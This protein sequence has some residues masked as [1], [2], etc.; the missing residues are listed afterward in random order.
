MASGTGQASARYRIVGKLGGGG[1]GVVFKAEDTSLGRFV[2]LKLLP[3]NLARDPL[4]LE[5]LRREARAASALDHPNICTVYDITTQDGQLAIAMQ[6]LEG[7]TLKG[8]LAGGVALAADTVV[9]LGIQIADALAAAHAKGIIHRD[10]KPANI[11]VTS[12]GQAKVLDFGLAK[13]EATA[14]PEA[15]TLDA[16]PSDLT[17]PGTTLGTAAYMSPE[18]ALGEPLDVRSDLFSLGTVLYEMATGRLP[19]A[20]ATSVAISDAILHKTPTPPAQLNPQLPPELARIIERALEKD[21]A[22]RYQS[23]ADLEADLKRLKRD[24]DSAHSSAAAAAPP[25][26]APSHARRRWIPGVVAAAIIAAALVFFFANRA[27]AM[28]SKDAILVTALTN[29]TGNTAF[30]GTLRTALEVSLE[31]SPYFNVVSDQQIART[32]ALMEQPAATVVTADIGQQIC[33]RDQIKALLHPSIASL[34]SQYV[35]T[36]QALDA[37]S[38]ATLAETEA[39]ANSASEVLA[40]L[41][42]AATELRR[43]LGESLT[44]IHQFNQPLLE[45]TTSSLPAL[46]AF[47]LADHDLDQGD[48]SAAISAAQQAIALDPNFAMAYRVL[49]VAYGNNG[50]RQT[51]A[52]VAAKA[53]TLR[54]RASEKEKLLITGTYYDFSGQIE[55]TIQTYRFYVQ[56]YPRGTIG[57]ENLGTAY[58]GL[59]EDAKALPLYLSGIQLNRG[60][61]TGYANAG[62]TYLALGRPDEAKAILAEAAARTSRQ[63]AVDILS[64]N[65]ALAAMHGQLQKSN[66]LNAQATSQARQMGETF[67]AELGLQAEGYNDA[68]AGETAPALRI[69]AQAARQ[70][71][72]LQAMAALTEAQAGDDAAAAALIQ[73]AAQAEPLNTFFQSVYLPDVQM[74]IALHHGDTARALALAQEAE[75][76]NGGFADGG[77]AP[78]MYICGN[79]D[80][81]AGKAAAAQQEFEKILSHKALG[82]DTSL[83]ITLSL[84]QLGLARAD[85]LARRNVQ[86]RA[87]YQDFFAL[88]QHADPS[89]PLLKRA[90]SE[91][92]RL[93]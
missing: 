58:A 77:R 47:T 8:K 27:P 37:A 87:A 28:T 19:F 32:L 83:P 79:V 30:D 33:Q 23:A 55:K 9:D 26:P 52:Q 86:A 17:S 13:V 3:D 75:S 70:A 46:R 80:L 25:R 91:Y 20:G 60:N 93:P 69:A 29:T 53:F 59:G 90:Q 61:F 15:P 45:A 63:G 48:D 66:A 36:L 84:A 2:A 89:L 92:S 18:Q 31:Q 40:A 39:T 14:D 64:D 56:T 4:A 76:F 88:W 21:R 38:G 73:K 44:S 35:I 11:F 50:D 1:M 74:V 24:S 71:P 68:M 16:A 65:A 78:S 7:V 6:F 42:K 5:R 82:P 43:K 49:A 67:Q 22:L 85:A 41:G 34:G 10:V 81:A 51:A 12:R 57:I 72:L 54:D 62:F